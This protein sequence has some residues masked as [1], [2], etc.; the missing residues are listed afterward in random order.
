VSFTFARGRGYEDGELRLAPDGRGQVTVLR[1]GDALV[2]RRIFL[3][4]GQ[5]Q[6][7]QRTLWGGAVTVAPASDPTELDTFTGPAGQAARG[8]MLWSDLFFAPPDP[9][10][11]RSEP[12]RVVTVQKAIFGSG[13][14]EFLGVIKVVLLSDGIDALM[15]QKVDPEMAVDPHRVFLCDHLGRLISRLGRGDRFALVDEGGKP[16]DQG[17]DLRVI[18][19]AL[20]REVAAVLRLPVIGELTPGQ[21]RRGRLE[22]PEPDGQTTPYL[23]TVTALPAGRTYEWVVGIVVPESHYLRE[24]A[25]SR[26]RL[27]VAAA[28]VMA[29]IVAI[30]ALGL[31]ALRGDLGRL[32]RETTRLRGFDFAPSPAATPLFRDVEAASQSLEQAKTALRALSKYAPVDLVRQL[33]E[34]RMEPTLGGQLHDVTILFS[35]IEGF[36]SVSEQL[37]TDVLAVALG[38]YLEVMTQAIHATGG[39]IDKYTGDG[40]MALWNTPS[41]LP[42]HPRRACE[43]A[44]RCLEATGSLFDSLAWGAMPPWRTRFG[45]H[46]AEVS[47]GHFGAPD[48]MS[49]TAMGDGV[50]LAARL[51]GLNKQ[52]GTSVLVSAMVAHEVRDEFLLRRLDRVAVK[53][54]REGIEVYELVGRAATV[55]RTDT[56]AAYEAALD[57]YFARRFDSAITLLGANGDDRP[58]Q[59]L[60]TRCQHFLAAPPPS[61][62]NGVFVAQQ[63]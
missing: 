46:R 47:V 4:D 41:P 36:T 34:A 10:P 12:A 37:S 6:S 15:H 59:V 22:V 3:L 18:P 21:S 2:G 31:R 20:P 58:S 19:A 9:G 51:E 39:I 48:R 45:I 35:D 43:A 42:Q 7:E 24:L 56:I 60:A 54:R 62:W 26:R 8:R 57:N 52:Y 61:D 28:L 38:Q 32:I 63:K 44:L 53:G 40:V 13:G 5:W 27:L 17:Q 1:Q 25:A 50:N 29:G 11:K 55:P 16:D 30:G 23:A 33:Y 14:R 49:F